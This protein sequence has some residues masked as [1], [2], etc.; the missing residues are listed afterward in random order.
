MSLEAI[1]SEDYGQPIVV[2][3]I[4]VDTGSAAD[5][6]SYATSKAMIFKSPAGVQISKAASFTTDG[7]DGM[8]EY[9]VL[10]T[11]TTLLRQPGT[12][13]I[14][15]RVTS[16]TAKLSTKWFEFTLNP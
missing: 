3:F 15:G 9:T 1:V 13:Q 11:D 2:I 7:S 5:I 16:A 10:S 12:W 6:S 14:R 4:D 8:I